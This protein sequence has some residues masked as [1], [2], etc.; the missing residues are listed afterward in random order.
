MRFSSYVGGGAIRFYLPLDVQLDNDFI[1]ETVVV[2]KDLEARDRVKARLESLLASD[3]P[4]VTARVSRLELGPP[5]GWPL[6]YRVSAPTIDEARFHAE[7]VGRVLRASGLVSTVTYDW[8]EKSKE[9]RIVVDQDRVRQAGLSSEQLAQALNRVISGA[10]VTRLRDSIYLVDVVARAETGE[11]ASVEALRN[12][13]ITTPSGAAV[14]LRELA[15][16]R[17]RPRRRLRLAPRPAAHDYR[18][19]RADC[20]A[21]SRASCMSRSP[22]R[23]TN[24]AR[25]CRRGPCSRSAARWRR[26]PRATPPSSRR[27]R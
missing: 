6:Q 23:S 25:R 13:Q 18:S 26:A 11:R 14:P 16:A 20:Q 24:C 1:A 4:D 9:L 19:G 2:A 17:V 7:E 27:R 3:F 15:Q 12:L 21:S 10:T 5:V 22:A 8:A